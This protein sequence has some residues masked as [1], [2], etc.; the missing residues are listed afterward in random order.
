MRI[1]SRYKARPWTCLINRGLGWMG[2]GSIDRASIG[3]GIGDV[4]V[5]RRLTQGDQSIFPCHAF[6]HRIVIPRD[7]FVKWF[8]RGA[9]GISQ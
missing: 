2:D 8:N 5:K 1:Q 4:L 3:S 9:S 7:G 6:G